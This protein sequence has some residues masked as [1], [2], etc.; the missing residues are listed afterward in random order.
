MP[1]PL[2]FDPAKIPVRELPEALARIDDV[3]VLY[4]LADADPRSTAD[5]RY[6]ERIAEIE[7]AGTEPAHPNDVV[8]APDLNGDGGDSSGEEPK[9]DE[10]DGETVVGWA[11]LNPR[12]V[13]AD[14]RIADTDI[15]IAV[16]ASNRS[17][18]EDATV[19]IGGRIFSLFEIRG[20]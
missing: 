7:E 3:G 20:A 8:V 6:M 14:V 13:A 17:E 15:P 9:P 10:I 1:D 18:I 11:Y 5:R 19:E 2:P 16:T 4:K 12:L